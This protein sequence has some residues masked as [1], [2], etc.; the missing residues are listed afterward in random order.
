MTSFD[1]AIEMVKA[2]DSKKAK[3]IQVVDIKGLSTL[4]D[5]FVIASGQSTTQVRALADEVDE[6]LSKLG[7]EPKRVE[8]YGSSLW[9]L[10]DYGDVIVHLFNQETREFYALERLWA[11]GKQVDLTGVVTPD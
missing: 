10:Q 9:I 11:D 7:I 4:G 1:M 3:D 2:L 6:R 5:Y 8:G